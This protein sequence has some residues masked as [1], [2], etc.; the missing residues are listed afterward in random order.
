MKTI[1]ANITKKTVDLNGRRI[2]LLIWDL[3]GQREFWEMFSSY[4]D[5]ANGAIIVFDIT[6][7][8]TLDHVKDWYGECLKHDIGHV[9]MIL[10]GNKID[11][12][13][14]VSKG[15][16]KGVADKMKVPYFETSA[17]HGESVSEIFFTT[18]KCVDEYMKR[19]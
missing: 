1:G 6:R 15:E 19:R 7:K 2:Q 16:G 14:T 10:V 5:G 9:P 4:F 3:A 12:N 8:E 18:A 13:R 11:L 17:K